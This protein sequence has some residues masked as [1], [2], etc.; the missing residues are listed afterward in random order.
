MTRIVSTLCSHILS[1]TVFST[2]LDLESSLSCSAPSSYRVIKGYISLG[3][4]R[5]HC[6]EKDHQGKNV[7]T[8]LLWNI[9]TLCGE[10][11]LDF[12]FN[13]LVKHI[14]YGG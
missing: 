2:C 5:K 9:R 8:F 7:K 4:A 1:F 6:Q 13:L 11:S 12:S 3:T 10:N 14:L